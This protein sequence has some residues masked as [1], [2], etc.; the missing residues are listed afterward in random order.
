MATREKQSV[1]IAT[2]DVTLDASIY[3]RETIDHRRVNIFAE[4]LR[5]DFKFDP[6]EVQTH[7]QKHGKYRILDGAHRWHAY[8]EVG[9]TK[10]PGQLI[11]LTLT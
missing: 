3:P 6:I 10:I 2:S 11:K 9:L 8:K 1:N 5:E 4:N 7:P